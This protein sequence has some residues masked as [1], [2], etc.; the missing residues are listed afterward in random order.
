MR[1]VFGSKRSRCLSNDAFRAVIMFHMSDSGDL[2]ADRSQSGGGNCKADENAYK[3]GEETK[4]IP[5]DFVKD[6]LAYL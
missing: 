3:V 6:I 2:V 5:V 4:C 1:E